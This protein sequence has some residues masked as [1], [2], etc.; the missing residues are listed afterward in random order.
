[1]VAAVAHEPPDGGLEALA[2]RLVL[3]SGPEVDRVGEREAE[4]VSIEPHA[5]VEI[6][7]VEAEMA[8]S[9]ELERPVEQDSA[10]VEFP[11]RGSFHNPSLPMAPG[12]F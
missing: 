1:M 12:P 6:H 7:G 11:R 2:H 3:D 5:R 8:E 9:A 4:Q 10:D